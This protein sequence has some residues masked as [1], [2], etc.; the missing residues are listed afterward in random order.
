M[1]VTLNIEEVRETFEILR[2]FANVFVLNAES[3]EDLFQH[4]EL[5]KL[6]SRK[7]ELLL[8]KRS[9]FTKNK[10]IFEKIYNVSSE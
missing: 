10:A 6:D 1:S 4:S 8:K 9:D 3:M 5:S 2:G 7:K